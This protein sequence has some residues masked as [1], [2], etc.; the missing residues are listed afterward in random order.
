MQIE[1]SPSDISFIALQGGDIHRFVR[2]LKN[3]PSPFTRCIL[4]TCWGLIV[5]QFFGPKGR[6]TCAITIGLLDITKEVVVND[7]GQ[8]VDRYEKVVEELIK[9]AS[10]KLKLPE[11]D[12]ELKRRSILT[13]TH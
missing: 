1:I 8:Y 13:A 9:R 7:Q 6:S 2:L 4:N 5:A 10:D 3:A 11:E 12:R